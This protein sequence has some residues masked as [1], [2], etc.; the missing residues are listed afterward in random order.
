MPKFKFTVFEGLNGLLC[1]APLAEG[2]AGVTEPPNGGGV[3][4]TVLFVPK[5]ALNACCWLPFTLPPNEGELFLVVELDVN[6]NPLLC[7]EAGAEKLNP[8]AAC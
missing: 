5:P 2:N 4:E 3:G 1:E 8:L 7:C 6:P